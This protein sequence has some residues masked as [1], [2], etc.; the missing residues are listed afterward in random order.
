MTP[1]WQLAFKL[2]ATEIFNDDVIVNHYVQDGIC[3]INSG[4]ASGGKFPLSAMRHIKKIVRQHDKVILS[5]E[6]ESMVRHIT[7]I[8]GGVF[9]SANKTYTKG[10]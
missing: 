6:V 1:N 4:S 9:D 7:V 8:Y 10:I 2:G 5:S 3:V